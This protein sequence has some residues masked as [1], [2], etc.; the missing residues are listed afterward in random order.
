MEIKQE[1]ENMVTVTR[2]ILAISNPS[3]ENIPD[4][5]VEDTARRGNRRRRRP[6]RRRRRTIR[7]RR[8][9]RRNPKAARARIRARARA[10]AKREALKRRGIQAKARRRTR[11]IRAARA[12]N[13]RT[14]TRIVGGV[15][16]KVRIGRLGA[17]RKGAAVVFGGVVN[18]V[19]QQRF[20]TVAEQRKRETKQRLDKRRKAVALKIARGAQRKISEQ[21]QKDRRLARSLGRGNIK[22]GLARLA[23][24]RRSRGGRRG[25]RGRSSALAR[26]RA[27][28]RRRR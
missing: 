12:R 26:A 7:R 15:R 20:E 5:T 1:D 21:R 4:T 23:A 27:R 11:I 24:I 3:F 28:R 6:T 10:Q 25:R 19:V 13:T 2:E 14:V 8:T 22:R 9:P 17:G 18:G 16:R